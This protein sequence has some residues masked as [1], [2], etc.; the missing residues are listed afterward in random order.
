MMQENRKPKQ[1]KMCRPFLWA[2]LK[3]RKITTNTLS[4]SS[5]DLVKSVV[6]LVKHHDT[7]INDRKSIKRMISKF[8]LEQFQDLLIL[9]KA[10]MLAQS[11]FRRKEKQQKIKEAEEILNDLKQENA[12]FKLKDLKI[13]G[14]DL[15]GIGYS[16]GASWQ[17]L[18][19]ISIGT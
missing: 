1:Q 10:D 12:C 17:T 13:N 18:L 5:N 15:L 14:K 2:P 7:D 3:I 11:E 16:Q 6:N 9:K 4:R 19:N 8:G